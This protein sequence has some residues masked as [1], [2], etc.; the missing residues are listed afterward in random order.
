MPQLNELQKSIIIIRTR[1]EEEMSIRHMANEINVDKN[2][3]LL[4][5]EK[6]RKLKLLEKRDIV[7]ILLILNVVL[8]LYQSGREYQTLMKI[9]V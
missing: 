4:A 2:T 7:G 3:I 8:K 1:L 9:C 5:K 6:L